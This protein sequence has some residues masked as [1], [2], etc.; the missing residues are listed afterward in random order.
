MD[1]YLTNGTRSIPK[2]VCL[3]AD[4]LE[5]IGTW[6]PRPAILQ[7]MAT[8]HKKNPVMAD[9]LFKESLQAWYA[10]DKAQHL[11]QEFE[12]LLVKWLRN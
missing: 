4:T 7:Q 1:K 5:E 2:L 8:E 9:S 12:D 6:G 3:K 11:Q 10:K